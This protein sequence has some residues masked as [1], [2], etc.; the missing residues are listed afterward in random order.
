MPIIMVNFNKVSEHHKEFGY[1]KSILINLITTRGCTLITKRMEK[2][3]IDGPM[4][5]FIKA[6]LKMI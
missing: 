6:I 2:V 3:F 1:L 4:E 5:M